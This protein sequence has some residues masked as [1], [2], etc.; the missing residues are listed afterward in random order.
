MQDTLDS[1]G[2]PSPFFNRK[3]RGARDIDE[4]LGLVKGILLDGVVCESEAKGL[5]DWVD[6]H[7]D[8]MDHPVGAIL[9]GELATVFQD[10]IV[11]AEEQL[12]LADFLG[13]LIGGKEESG[14]V[15]NSAASDLP[16]NDPA[17]E[18]VV[19]EK[20]FVFTGK[21]NTTRKLC[22]SLTEEHGG[23]SQKSITQ[24]TDF[25]VVGPLGS[26]DWKHSSFGTKI[27]KAMD[28]RDRGFPIAIVDESHWAKALELGG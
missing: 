5:R 7:P 14:D 8:V 2:Q 25:L 11:D 10:G 20:N 21:F 16:L 28:Y 26:R 3:S 24:E 19:H 9:Y 27:L 17:P 12:H 22:I 1:D 15:S 23:Y 4:M 6:A 18:I 13:K